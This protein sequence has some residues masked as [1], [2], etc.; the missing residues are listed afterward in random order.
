MPNIYPRPV[1][2]MGIDSPVHSLI[3]LTWHG[4]VVSPYDLHLYVFYDSWWIQEIILRHRGVSRSTECLLQ[5]SQFLSC[6]FGTTL[7]SH[8]DDVVITCC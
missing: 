6:Q 3:V 7:A 2:V 8:S 5:P 1:F 4:E